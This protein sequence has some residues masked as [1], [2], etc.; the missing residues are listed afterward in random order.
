MIDGEFQEV[1]RFLEETPERIR[2]LTVDLTSENLKW[3]PSVNEFSV[4]EQI[5]HL[6]DLER[7]GY[8]ARIRKLLTE[9]QPTLPDFDGSRIASERDYNSQ[10]FEAAFQEF[11]LERK[12][13]VRVMKALSSDQLN[14]S[15]VLEGVGAITLERLCQLMRE[16][17]QSHREELSDLRELICKK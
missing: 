3:K 2:R 1:V 11:A 7:E 10:D 15:G 4:L 5:C 9:E 12:E 14:R 13:N 16:H 17:D 8:N 6:R